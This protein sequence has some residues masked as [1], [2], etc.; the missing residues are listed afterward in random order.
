MLVQ[1]AAA[2]PLPAV[3][4]TYMPQSDI[5]V[6]Y[7]QLMRNIVQP[8]IKDFPVQPL[9]RSISTMSTSTRR[10]MSDVTSAEAAKVRRA[11]IHSTLQ[12]PAMITAPMV[13][14]QSPYEKAQTNI[15]QQARQ[16]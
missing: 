2:Q 3:M 12:Q 4:P 8:P 6:Q 15:V 5:S 7:S 13:A 1:Q 11:S 16:I 10:Q 9:V 14:A